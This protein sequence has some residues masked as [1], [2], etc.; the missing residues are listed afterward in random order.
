MGS[1]SAGDTSSVREDELPWWASA[2]LAVLVL[3]TLLWVTG[4][5]PLVYVG[6]PVAFGAAR[7][8][9]LHRRQRVRR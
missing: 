6:L 1:G 2:A 3:G 7:G 4:A 9:L 5:G 8:S